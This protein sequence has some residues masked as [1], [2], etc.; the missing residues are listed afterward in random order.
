MKSL[1]QRLNGCV[2]RFQGKP[3]ELYDELK[4]IAKTLNEFHVVD[5]DGTIIP[6]ELV[7]VDVSFDYDLP[8]DRFRIPYMA[9]L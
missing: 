8:T 7:T 6:S 1:K 4:Q 5:S 2:A 3:N 9:I